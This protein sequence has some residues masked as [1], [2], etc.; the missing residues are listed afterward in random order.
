MSILIKNIESKVIEKNN[1]RKESVNPSSFLVQG[2]LEYTKKHEPGTINITTAVDVKCILK[3]LSS[4]KKL[5]EYKQEG[6]RERRMPSLPST[7]I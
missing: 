2:V 7:T 5:D 1:E 6:K 3:I 4:N